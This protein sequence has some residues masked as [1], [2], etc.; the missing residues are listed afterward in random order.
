MW[1]L[2]TL[3]LHAHLGLLPLHRHC[4]LDARAGRVASASTVPAL[5][6][7][8]LRG[9]LGGR[10]LRLQDRALAL[11]A[12]VQVAIPLRHLAAERRDLTP[13]SFILPLDPTVNR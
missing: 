12:L 4:S 2:P 6:L 10:A 3:W 7:W 11:V 9:Q 8:V 13:K 5:V 1:P